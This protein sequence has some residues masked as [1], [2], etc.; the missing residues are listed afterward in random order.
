[1]KAISLH[2][3]WASAMA[4]GWKSN[5]TRHWAAR[6]RGPLLIHAAK[7]VVGW[8]SIDMQI[9]FEGVAFQPGDLP[10][11]AIL[12]QV[13]MVDC[14]VIRMHN[15]PEGLERIMGNYTLGRYMWITENVKAFDPIPYRGRQGF[16]KVPAKVIAKA[17]AL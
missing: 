17:R 2:Q 9:A 11:G 13:E 16:F 1:M 14:Q 7:K 6:H 15:R 8:P 10:R 4:L 12:C 5:E 3:P